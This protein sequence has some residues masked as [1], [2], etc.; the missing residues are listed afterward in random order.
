MS[1]EELIASFPVKEVSYLALVILLIAVILL[2]CAFF[3]K[4]IS[5]PRIKRLISPIA[6]SIAFVFAVIG[7]T[8][9]SV[10]HTNHQQAIHDWKTITYQ[11]YLEDQLTIEEEVTDYNVNEDGSITAIAVAADRSIVTYQK[12]R[13][14][15][16]SSQGRNYISYVLVSGLESVGIPDGKDLITLHLKDAK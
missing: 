6:G 8:I 9:A 1:T 5:P 15:E 11:L 2:I 3:G 14:I 12:L 13:N 16:P 4:E 7:I 10:E